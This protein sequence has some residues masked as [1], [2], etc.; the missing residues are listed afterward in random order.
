M[1]IPQAIILGIVQGLTEFL[2]VSSSGHL[3]LFQH[4]MGLKEIPLAFDVLLHLA[5]LLAVVIVLSNQINDLFVKSF[6]A[7]KAR[8]LK[9]I[10]R[11]IWLLIIGSLPAAIIGF[12]FNDYMDN[13][14]QSVKYFSV[15]FL[16]TSILLNIA[17]RMKSKEKKLSEMSF[18]ESLK[19]GLFQAIAIFPS[20]SR[21]GSTISGIL[22]LGFKPKD[23]FTFSFLLSIPAILGAGILHIK[24]IFAISSNQFLPYSVGFISAA[25]SGYLALLIFRKTLINKKL[26]VFAYYCFFLSLLIFFFIS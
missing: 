7:I 3:A 4:F 2:P 23:A 16:I 17:N 10:P 20:I 26:S 14:F 8:N 5:T 21:S 18:S 15:G 6:R 19:V 22:F 12:A 24:Q 9:Q 25:L 11:L 1:S 13:I